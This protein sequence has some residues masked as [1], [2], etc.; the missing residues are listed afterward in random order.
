MTRSKIVMG[1]FLLAGL[2]NFTPLAGVLGDEML[3][4]AY[5]V[6]IESAELS[7]LLRHRAILF[8]IIGGLLLVA[9]FRPSLRPVATACGMASMVSFGLLFWITQPSSSELM[10][11][12]KFDVVGIVALGTGWLLSRGQTNR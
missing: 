6:S 11:V 3:N 7:L 5:G 9:A 10:G 4:N 12:L 2:I 8:G 1:L